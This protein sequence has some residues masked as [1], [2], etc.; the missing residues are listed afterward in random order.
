VYAANS[1]TFLYAVFSPNFSTARV[2]RKIQRRMGK[3]DQRARRYRTIRSA[4]KHPGE[5]PCGID[6]L[7]RVNA[8]E[9][10]AVGVSGLQPRTPPLCGNPFNPVV[11]VGGC[12]TVPSGCYSYPPSCSDSPCYFCHGESGR[13]RRTWSYRRACSGQQTRDEPFKGSRSPC[14]RFGYCLIEWRAGR[15]RRSFGIRSVPT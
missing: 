4:P 15:L 1:L 14:W 8:E 10:R 12:L 9:S 11:V 2:A 13:L 3:G 5:T 7:L 6:I